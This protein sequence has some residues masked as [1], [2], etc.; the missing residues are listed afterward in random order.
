MTTYYRDVQLAK[1]FGVDRTTIWRWVRLNEF[2]QPVRLSKGC[3]R[4]REEDIALWSREKNA[5]K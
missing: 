2:P 5:P 4:W 1:R 3:T